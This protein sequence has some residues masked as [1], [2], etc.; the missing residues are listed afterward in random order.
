[1]K[2]RDRKFLPPKGQSRRLLS[3]WSDSEDRYIAI[4]IMTDVDG[5]SYIH[6]PLGDHHKKAI[7]RASEILSRK[8][9]RLTRVNVST[10]TYRV[11]RKG[12]KR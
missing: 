11:T 1:M 5:D 9:Y 3:Q 8:G 12:D 10:T 7:D 4:G 6:C 2:A